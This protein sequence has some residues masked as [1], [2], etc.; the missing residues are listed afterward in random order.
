[1]ASHRDVST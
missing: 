1:M